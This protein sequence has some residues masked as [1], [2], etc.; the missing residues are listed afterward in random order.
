MSFDSIQDCNTG[1]DMVGRIGWRAALLAAVVVAIVPSLQVCAAEEPLKSYKAAAIVYDP[2]WGDLDG[3]IARISAAVDA[4]GAQGVK[5][6]VLPEQATIGYIFDSFAMVRPY[7][8]TIPGKTTDALSKVTMRHHMYVAVGIAELDPVTGLGYNTAALVGPNGY[9]GKY[10]KHGLNPQDQAWVTPGDGGFPVF[11]TELGRLSML[12]C[13]DDTYW[14]YPR[15]AALHNVDVVAWLSSSDRVTPGTPPAQAK[16]D[17]STVATVQHIAAFNGVWLVAATRDGIEKNPQ[18]GQT[19]YYNGGSSIWDPSGNKVAQAPV[20]QPE[21][22]SPGAHGMIVA[23]ITPSMSAPV[24]NAVLARRR[25]GMYGLLALHR[26]P[27]DSNATTTPKE[28]MVKAVSWPTSGKPPA[29]LPR[30]PREGLLVLPELF[31]VGVD[32][33]N[34]AYKAAAE[35]RGGMAEQRLCEA[36]KSGAGYVVGSYP[37]SDGGSV[38]HTVALAGPEGTILARY[39]ATH[40]PPNQTEWAKEGSDWVVVPTPIGRIGLTL[41]EEL[42]VPEVFGTLSALRA[43]LLAAPMGVPSGVTMQEDPKLFNQP[44]PPET[45][46]APMAAAKLGQTWVAMSGWS[47]G[48]HISAAVFG[49]E[50]VI[51]TPPRIPLP[52]KNEV[53]TQITIAWPGTWLNQSHLIDGQRPAATLPITLDPASPCFQKWASDSGWKY[54]C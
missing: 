50:P 39:R 2:A 10:R 3:N 35:P 16:G 40:L 53:E 20:V 54:G 5:L 8:D 6:A 23:E 25:P 22:L 28:I 48:Q 11:D 49:P 42:S 26:A 32:A 21:V 30:P 33:G 7:L 12:I 31:S 51:A 52:G 1:V 14:Q 4:A 44:Y 27:T 13:Y 38:Y 29:E 37:E 18:T 45:P 43:D 24:R 34:A 47:D 15:L 9:I 41:G 17:H 46:F 19:L 36:A